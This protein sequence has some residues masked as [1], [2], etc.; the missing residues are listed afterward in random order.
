VAS[1]GFKGLP[2][3]RALWLVVCFVVLTAE[4][5]LGQVG[6]PP[7]DPSGRS[8][9]P[10]PVQNEQPL[11]PKEPPAEILPPLSRCLKS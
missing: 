5:V 11:Q 2:S 9:A 4:M 8:G 10:P 3:A 6:L 1:S 7:I